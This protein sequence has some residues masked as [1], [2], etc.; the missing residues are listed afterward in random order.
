MPETMVDDRSEWSMG[1]RQRHHDMCME[2]VFTS[3][4][5]GLHKY[6]SMFEL[7]IV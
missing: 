5:G 4:A 6:E 7:S 3:E 1:S 2:D